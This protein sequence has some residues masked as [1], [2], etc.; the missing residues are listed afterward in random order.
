LLKK[1]ERKANSAKDGLARAKARL[2]LL[3][4][5][6]RLKPCRC[7]KATRLSFSA[8][9]KE[10][11]RLSASRLFPL[12]EELCDKEDHCA[13]EQEPEGAALGNPGLAQGMSRGIGL[14]QVGFGAACFAIWVVV[15]WGGG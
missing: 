13:N 11:T 12:E 6:A 7:Y 15:D 14:G 4:L 9:W 1:S 3:I 10:G 5:L 2:I 8:S